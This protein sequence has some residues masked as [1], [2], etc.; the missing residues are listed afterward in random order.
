MP[1]IRSILIVGGPPSGHPLPTDMRTFAN[2]LGRQVLAQGYVLLNGCMNE[3]DK[4]IAEGALAQANAGPKL[5]AKR[6]IRSWVL[7][8]HEPSHRIGQ[9]QQSALSSWDPGE[10]PQALPEPIA[11]AD[12]VV[13]VDGERGTFRTANLARLAG[14]PVLPVAVFGGAAAILYDN[15]SQRLASGRSGTPAP[16]FSVLNAYQPSDWAEY[17]AEV[18]SLAGRMISGT[19]VFVVMSFRPESDDTYGTIERVCRDFHL[20]AIRTDKTME[21]ERIFERIVRG[22]HDAALVIV[23]VSFSSPNIYY[24][25]GYAE[26]LGKTVIVIAKE[27][28]ELPFDTKDIPTL[29]WKDQTRL[30]SALAAVMRQIMGLSLA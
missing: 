3:F 23:D 16:D 7:S 20:Q 5:D 14:K 17:A 2:E 24:E 11:H 1:E 18:V 22:I 26:A 12:A 13:L 9:L 25:L 27:G 10:G 21:T 19:S 15:E 30:A 28:T 8:G 6:S 4:V 29:F